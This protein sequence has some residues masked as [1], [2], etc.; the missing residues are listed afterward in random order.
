MRKS[1]LLNIHSDLFGN[2]QINLVRD[3]LGLSHRNFAYYSAKEVKKNY[4]LSLQIF[5]CHDLFIA[6]RIEAIL[7]IGELHYQC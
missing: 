1:M 3:L 4:S 5:A 6:T 2:H 7:S